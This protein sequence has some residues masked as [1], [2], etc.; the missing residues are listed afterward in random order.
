MWLVGTHCTSTGPP[1]AY[2]GWVLTWVG[3]VG[4]GV[5]VNMGGWG[6]RQ[7]GWMSGSEVG[8]VEWGWDAYGPRSRG[9]V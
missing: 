2:W 1:T 5:D 9:A 4:E 8:W 3:G 7:H 6:G